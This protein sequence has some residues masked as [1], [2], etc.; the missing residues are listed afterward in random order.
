MAKYEAT[1]EI[2]L[3][4]GNTLVAGDS[5]EAKVF[6]QD[7]KSLLEQGYLTVPGEPP[8]VP[9][10]TK[11]TVT[12]DLAQPGGIPVDVAAAEEEVQE[13]TVPLVMDGEHGP[14]NDGEQPVVTEVI[15]TT[16]ETMGQTVTTNDPKDGE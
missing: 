11:G 8:L 12:V 13:E 5:A 16:A 3:A 7:V 14:T 4:N 6:G 9:V 1:T 15:T 2:Y 10:P